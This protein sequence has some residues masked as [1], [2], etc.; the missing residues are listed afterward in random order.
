MALTANHVNNELI[1]FRK[2]AATDFL[3]SSRFDPYMGADSTFPIVRM[4]DLAADGKEIRVPLVTQLIGSGVGAGTLRGNEEQIDS[5]GMPVWAD[6]ARN[7]VANN[8]AV[9]KES[10]FSI[11]ST[12]RSLLSGW[13][14][15]VVRDDLIDALLS[16][17]TASVQSNRLIAPGNRVNGLRWS[18]AQ[19]ADK[20]TW[21]TNNY[22]RVLFG[23]VLSNHYTVATGAVATFAT[24]AGN[25]DTTADK[26][27]AAIGSY[28]KQIAMQSGVSSSNP[29]VYNGRPK[30]TPFQLKKTDQ[31]W[32]VCFLGSR[33]MRD[34]K[35]DPVMYQANRDAR[36]RESS[37]TSNNP[38]FTGGGL[39]Y[40]GIIYLEMPE[41]TQRLLL[42]AAG[43]S[44]DVEPFFLLGQG[45]MAYAVG[46]MPRPTTLEDGD[47]DFITG[48]GVEAQFGVAKI[49]KAPINNAAGT[50]LVDWG[51]A[52]G[53][54]AAPASA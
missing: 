53:F 5:Y 11:R 27:T 26:M 21:L 2:D 46:Q 28:L 1:K 25:C 14:R 6:W 13:S 51:M 31:E 39:V 20:N 40:D 8:R 37:P 29:G 47:Y 41:I 9:D 33:A 30:I 12:A 54:V 49:A 36:E 42:V 52:T 35:A 7:A 17:P 38:I 10:S 19:A 24:A 23:A 3:R 45:A 43:S 48:M 50:G 22:D 4:K 16:I 34:L 18:A 32:Y 15:R 44:T